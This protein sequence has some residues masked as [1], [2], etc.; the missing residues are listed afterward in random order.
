VD[1]QLTRHVHDSIVDGGGGVGSDGFGSLD[2][3]EYFDKGF[4][5]DKI[6]FQKG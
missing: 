6:I 4:H 5:N 1:T 3:V 2:G